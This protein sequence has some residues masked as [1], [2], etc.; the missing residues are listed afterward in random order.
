MAHGDV[1]V[2]SIHGSI[3]GIRSI[4]YTYEDSLGI[5]HPYGP[6]QTTDPAFDIEAHKTT[7]ASSVAESLAEAEFRALEGGE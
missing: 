4:F 3:G 5:R 6:V 1:L 7:V 2:E